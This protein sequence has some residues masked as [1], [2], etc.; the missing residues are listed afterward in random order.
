MEYFIYYSCI[1]F[2]KEFFLWLGFILF[3]NCRWLQSVKRYWQ[4]AEKTIEENSTDS[5]K[6]STRK[7]KVKSKV[8]EQKKPYRVRLGVY[9]NVL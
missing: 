2:Q 6:N 1:S 8:K 5:E 7:L 9:Q 3:L 4:R